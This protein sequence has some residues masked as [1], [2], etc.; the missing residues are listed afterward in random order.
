MP[1]S[2]DTPL[3]RWETS[4]YSVLRV[5]AAIAR[6]TQDQQPRTPLTG[7][8]RLAAALDTSPATVDRAKRFLTTA[9]IIRKGENN[10]YYTT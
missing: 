8:R 2:D 6:Q 7:S 9:G 4:H 5:A 3:T 10:R 1:H